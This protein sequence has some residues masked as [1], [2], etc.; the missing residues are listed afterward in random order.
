MFKLSQTY[1]NVFLIHFSYAYY[2]YFTVKNKIRIIRTVAL[3]S[4]G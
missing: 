4:A 1:F 2:T 3:W